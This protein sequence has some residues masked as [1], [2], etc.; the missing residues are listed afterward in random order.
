MAL[1][2]S[3]RLTRIYAR[4]IGDA[5]SAHR[6]SNILPPGNHKITQGLRESLIQMTLNQPSPATHI[7][8]TLPKQPTKPTTPVTSKAKRRRSWTSDTDRYDSDIADGDVSEQKH[9]RPNSEVFDSPLTIPTRSHTQSNPQRNSGHTET[10]RAL[11]TKILEHLQDALTTTKELFT[12]TGQNFAVDD[13]IPVLAA[14]LYKTTTGQQNPTISYQDSLISEALKSL[15]EEVKQIVAKVNQQQPPRNQLPNPGLSAST[16]NPENACT[17]SYADTATSQKTNPPMA[18]N[19][20]PKALTNPSKAHHPTCLAIVFDST[21][22]PDSKRDKATTV[23]DI[24]VFLT[25]KG[26]PPD[27]KITAIKWNTQGNC[28]VFTRTD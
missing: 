11:R 21:L 27:L 3:R 8:T 13:H 10:H 14:N 17:K 24:N 1:T 15:T 23:Q 20:W 25:S 9:A 4:G 26:V 16:H 18:T 19:L 28:I 22:P 12:L 6:P 2:K 7:H 5:L